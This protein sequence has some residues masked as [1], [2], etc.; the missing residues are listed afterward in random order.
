MKNIQFVCVGNCCR[1]QMAE[2]FA[3]AYGGDVLNAE[4]AGLCPTSIIARETK[5]AMLEKNIDISAQFPKLFDP[6]ESKRFD[7]IVNMSGFELPPPTSPPVQKWEVEDPFGAS[8]RIYE[9]V[10]QDIENRVMRLILEL[11]R[12]ENGK[13]QARFGPGIASR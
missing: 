1:S 3:R 9:R 11:R 8:P 2:G 5:E 10:C 7:L 4:S 13:R 12:E 6:V